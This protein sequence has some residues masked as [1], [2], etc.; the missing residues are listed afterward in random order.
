MPLPRPVAVLV[1]YF[2]LHG[3]NAMAGAPGRIEMDVLDLDE[4][5]AQAVRRMDDALKRAKARRQG[6]A[7]YPGYGPYVPDALGE[8]GL[9][10]P[11]AL[12][13][14]RLSRDFDRH[15][16]RGDHDGYGGKHRDADRGKDPGKDSDKDRGGPGGG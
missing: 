15:D 12:D 7:E 16:G 11:A 6:P 10:V 4:P 9:L 13:A 3:G 14:P 1:L 2:A 5:P 8:R